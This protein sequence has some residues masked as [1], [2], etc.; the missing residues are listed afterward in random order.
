MHSPFFT[1]LS[2]LSGLVFTRPGRLRRVHRFRAAIYGRVAGANIGRT[3]AALERI[4][5]ALE[6]RRGAAA[7]ACLVSSGSLRAEPRPQ[8]SGDR[9]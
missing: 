6:S 2:S 7:A 4:A 5:D 9:R 1:L 8:S 3:R